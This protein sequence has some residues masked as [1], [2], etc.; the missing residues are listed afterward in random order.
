M[1]Y[2]WGEAVGLDIVSEGLGGSCLD[3]ILGQWERESS[4]LGVDIAQLGCNGCFW[5]DTHVY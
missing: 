4:M 1:G 3:G 5:V 2:G